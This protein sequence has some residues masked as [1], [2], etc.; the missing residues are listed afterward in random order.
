MAALEF[1]FDGHVRNQQSNST[2]LNHPFL[3]ELVLWLDNGAPRSSLQSSVVLRECW[4]L[5]ERAVAYFIAQ[6]T[7]LDASIIEALL[8][9]YL[10]HIKSRENAD[11]A[12]AL[13][14]IL[15]SL[16]Q[17]CPG[18][19]QVAR[20]ICEFL[21]PDIPVL[22]YDPLLDALVKAIQKVIM[23]LFFL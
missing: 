11:V 2:F 23:Y 20:I 16:L 13:N 3:V 12:A 6:A 14:N 10:Q 8:H 1:A 5:S 7:S 22:L 18:G 17:L 15:A 19:T 4:R 21:P 9:S